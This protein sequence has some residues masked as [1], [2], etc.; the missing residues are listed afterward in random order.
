VIGEISPFD[1]M[2]AAVIVYGSMLNRESFPLVLAC[3]AE[4]L[5]RENICKRLGIVVDASG[6]IA[7]AV[8]P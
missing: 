5:D 4:P 3:F 7:R 2:E 8:K 6:S 1:Q